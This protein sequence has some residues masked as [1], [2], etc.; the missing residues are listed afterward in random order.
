MIT[1]KQK[2]N[3]DTIKKITL[4]KPNNAGG[5]WQGITHKHLIDSLTKIMEEKRWVISNSTFYL[6]N[7]EA[8]MAGTFDISIPSI[9]IPEGLTLSLGFLTSNAM[10]HSL[11]I[12]IGT[13]VLIC[14][15]GM[16]VGEI[17]MKK[18]HT[19]QF[20][21]ITELIIALNEYERRAKLIPNIIKEMKEYTF[22]TIENEAEHILME[23]G[24]LNIM[25]WSRIGQVDKEY[26]VPSYPEFE[27]RNCWS[28]YNAFTLIVKQSPP[29]KQMEMMNQFRNLLPITDK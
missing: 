6:S 2:T 5:Y 16:V 1:S 8:D 18:K 13:V 26:R 10:R 19:I 15:N 3:Y 9:Q 23:A 22:N 4:E 14:L 11:K 21:L 17:L 12:V 24:R 29:L 25:P 7:D 28:L 20:D 27:G